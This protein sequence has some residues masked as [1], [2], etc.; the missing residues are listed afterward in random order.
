[1][2]CQGRVLW[3]IILGV[4]A[5]S[6][7][8][9]KEPEPSLFTLLAP[10]ET[11]VDFVNKLA[12]NEQFNILKYLYYYNGGGVAIGDVNRDSLPDL[13]FTANELPNKLYINKGDFTFT[14]I[15]EQ[16][17]V[18][19]LS[20]W[21]TGVTMA[22]VNGDGWLDLYVSYLGDYEGMKGRNQLF[23]NNADTSRGGVT[24]TEKAAAYGLDH[25][26][27][28]TQAAFFDYDNDGDLDVYLLNHTVHSTDTY[29]PVAR[30]RRRSAVG[31]KLMR[32]DGEKFI[33]VSEEAGIYGSMVGYGLSVSVSDVNQ[34]GCPDIYV[35]NDFH[36]NDY[37]YYNNC[38]GT[39]TESLEK[40]IGHTSRFSMGNDVADFNNDGK[41]D[42]VVLDMK[43]EDE[44]VLKISAG[45]DPYD[46]YQFKLKYGY[47]HQ[48]ARNTLQLNV[49]DSLYSE[50]GQ[51]AG[52]AA[53]DWSW[54][55]LFADLDLDGWKD[56]FITNGIYR[57]PNNLDYIK[58]SSSQEVQQAL[59]AEDFSEYMSLIRKMPSEKVA[60]YAYHNNRDLTFTNQ[61]TDWGLAQP[62]FSNGAAYADLDNDGDLD[63]V[64]NNID[65][66]A[67][68]YRNNAET[69][70]EHHYLKIKLQGT[71]KNTHGIGAKVFVYQQDK[72]QYQEM[73][74]TRGFESSVEPTL[75][76]GLG[77]NSM[78]D[79]LTV[80]WPDARKQTLTQVQAD[81]TLYLSQSEARQRH[82]YGRQETLPPV[83]EE[84]TDQ[85]GIDYQ[86]EEN[87]FIDFNREAL[88]PH[89]LSQEGPALAVGDVNGDSL[90]DLYVG[91]AKGQ[92][93][94]LFLQQKEGMFRK[95]AEAVWQADR[96]YEDVDAAFF[97]A[98]GDQD[99]DLYV[100]SAGNEFIREG[101]EDRLYLNN[102]QGAFTRAMYALPEIYA[103]TSCVRPSDIDQD[104]DMDLFVGSRVVT[105]RYGLNPD[106]YL[107]END[108]QGH[109]RDVTQEKAPALKQIGMVSDALWS[110]YDGDQRKD[111]ILVGE[112]MP[113]TVLKYVDDLW[114][115]AQIAGLEK[116]HGWWNTIAAADLDGDG[117][118]DFVAGNLGWN[119][120]IQATENQP[121]TLHVK[122][123][124]QNGS[125]DQ[126]LSFY[127]Q[128]VSYPFLTKDELTRQ[129]VPLRKK[130]IRYDEYANS[131]LENVFAPKELDSA[132]VK[133]AYQ[134]ATCIIENKGENTFSV[135]PLPTRAQ[136]APV[137]AI[138][139]HDYDHD[140]HQDLL[141]AG[142]FYAVG[143]KQGRYDASY[144]LV[145]KGNSHGNF[146]PLETYESGLVVKGETRVL[147]SLNH[148]RKYPLIITAKNNDRLQIFKYYENAVF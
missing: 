76:F 87:T 51:L 113:V 2:C 139:I 10:H 55:A 19:G 45:E 84:V 101:L 62:S 135:K 81:Q 109:F 102:G 26:S 67:F 66:P 114:Q 54:A 30:G 85:L 25:Q 34:D 94:S 63:L 136:F 100:A 127:K 4:L 88:M 56:L 134:F 17:G 70:R 91:G 82:T 92:A 44:R 146:V 95:A 50:I 130:Y 20:G 6:A 1:M 89:M 121:A 35:G 73:I 49:G 79:S 13:Y 96:N 39:F 116:T 14:D 131:S 93:G 37:L 65:E 27:F 90:E 123:F 120:V 74:P 41:P 77:K 23:I 118:Q 38:D 3:I 32:Q 33:D 60:N 124:D 64:V 145:L 18:A 46:I 108:G 12:E 78:L 138:A 16:A 111:L 43:P 110:D 103:N 132:L 137:H 99:L 59:Q 128:G 147:K 119:A 61:A 7:C 144:G 31:D 148:L 122:D 104:G 86:H 36:E 40:V 5:F 28:A 71:G 112:W 58:Y 115:V 8:R 126:V 117:D 68:L 57:R 129:I 75:V 141:L 97:D 11:G 142:N 9:E 72:L 140:G 21:T 29:V 47:N 107:L 15:T 105:G 133:K 48:Y 80:I 83:F 53:T 106:S 69:Q 42:L 125:L 98:D 22:D 24:F 52:V 143:P